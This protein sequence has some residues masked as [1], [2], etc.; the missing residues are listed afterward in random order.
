MTTFTYLNVKYEA[1]WTEGYVHIPCGHYL[2]ATWKDGKP[3]KI[4]QVKLFV[5]PAKY[6]I[7]KEVA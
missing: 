7:A 5:A 6:A 1:E 4:F 3:E 2:E